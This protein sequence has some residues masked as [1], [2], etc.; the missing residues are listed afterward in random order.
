M[1]RLTGKVAVI[2]GGASGI[3]AATCKRLVQEGARVAIGDLD[4]ERAR[5][6]AAELGDAALAVP[7]DAGDVA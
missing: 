4:A 2:T 6:L 1:N 7:F 3:G 5:A